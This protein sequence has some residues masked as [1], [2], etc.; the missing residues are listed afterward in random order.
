MTLWL[1]DSELVGATHRKQS[2]AREWRE[3]TPLEWG[4]MLLR[5]GRRRYTRSTLAEVPEAGGIYALADDE[6]Q[7]VYIGKAKNLPQRLA[8]HYQCARFGHERAFAMFGVQCVP[9]YA[10]GAVEVAH[11]HALQPERNRLYENASWPGHAMM[12][13]ALRQIWSME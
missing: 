3:A 13:A 11:I 2:A 12:V 4:S 9:E 8:Q 6:G 5:P 1:S 7:V 10:I